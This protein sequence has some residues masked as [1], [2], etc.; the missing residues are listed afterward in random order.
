MLFICSERSPSQLKDIEIRHNEAA[1]GHIDE[2]GQK[3]R[4][5]RCYKIENEDLLCQGGGI[6]V[7]GLPI[8]I[9]VQSSCNLS[10]ER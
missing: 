9:V 3:D 5:V 6:A 4:E 7:C 10:Q 1:E 2:G 8:L